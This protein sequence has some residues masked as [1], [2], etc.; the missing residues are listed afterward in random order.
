M[1]AYSIL[2]IL[3]FLL[4]SNA[5]GQTIITGKTVD[6]KG[7]PLPGVNVIVKGSYDG[8]SSDRTGNFSLVLTQQ[9]SLVLDFR[10]MGYKSTERKLVLS[11]QEISLGNIRLIEQITEMNAVT[12]SA[13]AMETTDASRAVILKPID[14]VTTPSAMGD[15]VSAL[16]TLPGTSSVGNDGRLFVRGGDA[17]EVGI[18]IDGLR[19]G[20]A[21]GTTAGNVPTRTRFN[22][23]LFKGT[24]FST[25]G[26][27][28]EYGQALSSTLALNTKDVSPRTQGDL[29]IMSVGGG[30]AQ[31]LSNEKQSISFS[32]NYFDLKPYQN[33]VKQ[34]FDWERSPYGIDLEIAAQQQLKKGGSI[35]ALARTETNGMQIWQ[36]YPG[37]DGR[38]N[39]VKLKNQ[40]SYAQSNW[41]KAYENG[42]AF[43]AGAAFSHNVDQIESEGI[44]IEQI[45]NLTH[46]KITA[47]KDYSDRLSAKS[48]V[49]TFIHNYS[50]TL[51][52][53]DQTRKFDENEAYL[54][55][56]W[57]WYLSKKLILR[58]G[59]RLGTSRLAKDTWID[60][61]VSLAYQITTYGQLSLAAGRFHQLPVDKYRVL[62]NSLHNTESKHLIL[63]YLYAHDGRTIRVESFLKS[64]NKLVTYEGYPEAPFHIKNSGNGSAR[65]FDV[66]F[67]DQSSFKN[68]DY[69]LSYGFVKSE[70]IY[71]H[72]LT[73]VQ[74]SYAPRQNFSFV[75]KHFV[76]T[77][78]SQLGGS[79]S[80]NDGYTYTNPNE[81]GQMNSKTKAY[82]SLS[83]SWSYL[84]RPNLIIHGAVNNVLGRENVFGYTYAKTPD[85][86]GHF[87]S[88]PNGQGSPRFLFLGLFLTLS[89]DKN[90]NFLNNL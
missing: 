67:R 13:G 88:L 46:L 80:A 66:F 8:T 77:L 62:N 90:A 71:D 34:D 76:P 28:A 89:K 17:S 83:L 47:I 73:Q 51:I 9:D 22:P 5:F 72:F 31:T 24:F 35:K 43:F 45:A 19:V 57:D 82:Q 85:E 56:E 84:P 11:Q 6:E 79:F 39:L 25:G 4:Q 18:Y 20:N 78:K 41:R 65:G 38:G 42:W 58:G 64:Y 16:Q 10:L 53:L 69:W 21:Y 48:G 14:T 54:F 50:E 60:P 55:S 52:N 61:R 36:P 33:L 1:R 32:A 2:F 23:N 29:N 75:I 37:K 44:P 12:I 74:P 63:N 87:A 68:T 30:Y 7:L 81:I 59:A 40:Y 70:R 26:Y 86:T 27:S 3:I 49:E 15:I